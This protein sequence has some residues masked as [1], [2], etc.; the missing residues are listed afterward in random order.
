MHINSSGKCHTVTKDILQYRFANGGLH[1][2]MEGVCIQRPTYT[3]FLD[4]KL[5]GWLRG[6]CIRTLGTSLDLHTLHAWCGVVGVIFLLNFLNSVYFINSK[7]AAPDYLLPFEVSTLMLTFHQEYLHMYLGCNDCW[8]N[9]WYHGVTI[10]LQ[11]LL[12]K[13]QRILLRD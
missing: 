6:F 5:T 11:P 12:Q 1:S 2:Q 4:P 7:I 8:K 10:V 9:H 3:L 13:L